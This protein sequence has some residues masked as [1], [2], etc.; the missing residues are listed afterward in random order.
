MES[1]LQLKNIA[2][3]YDGFTALDHI[4]LNIEQHTTLGLVGESGSGKSTLARVIAGL[5]APNEGEI[6]LGSQPLKKKRRKKLLSM[7]SKP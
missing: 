4:D 1:A 3:Q 2:V 5:I 7:L 6:W